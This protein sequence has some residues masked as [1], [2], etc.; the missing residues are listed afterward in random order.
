MLMNSAKHTAVTGMPAKIS[1][2]I[3]GQRWQSE[4]A[5]NRP[6]YRNGYDGLVNF[7]NAGRQGLSVLEQSLHD[8]LR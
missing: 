2:R 3:G 5:N 4:S 7:S 6:L 8:H 1:P